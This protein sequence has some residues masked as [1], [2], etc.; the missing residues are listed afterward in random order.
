MYSILKINFEY[1]LDLVFKIE[2]ICYHLRT[3]ANKSM[4]NAIT[5]QAIANEGLAKNTQA[6]RHAYG[7]LNSVEQAEIQ[8]SFC[9]Q[10]NISAPAFRARLSGATRVSDTELAW[11][12]TRVQ[13]YFPAKP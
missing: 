8:K 13:T 12:E 5:T 10:Y 9:R 1:F 6:F 3:I 7:R 4:S 11:F 2:Y